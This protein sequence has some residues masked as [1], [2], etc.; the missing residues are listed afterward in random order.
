[1]R[2]AFEELDY[3]PTPLGALSLRRRRDLVTGEDYFE[4]KLGDA[5]LMSSRFTTS[6]IELAR[7]GLAAARG[8]DLSVVVGGLG[9]GYTAAAVLEEARV[10]KLTVVELFQPVIDWHEQHLVPLG[11]TLTR[12]P[13]CRL[14]QGD[15]FALA[16]SAEGF[17]AGRRFDAVLLDIDHSPDFLLDPENAAFYTPEG[18]D[19]LIAH[20]APGGIFALWSND[21]PDERFTERLATV[22]AATRALP[23]TFDNPLQDRPVTQTV[24]LAEA[25]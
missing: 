13:R 22:F 16:A 14:V 23:V 6:E 3:R 8:T 19:R 15:F 21:P 17:D 1:M 4:V 18:L 7:L 2:P 12:D 20:L 11:L 5:F 9:L 25:P 10:A 24:Y